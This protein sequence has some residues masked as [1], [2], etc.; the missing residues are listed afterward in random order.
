MELTKDRKVN[1]ISNENIGLTKYFYEVQSI[2]LSEI[3]KEINKNISIKQIL[4]EGEKLKKIMPKNL[5][6]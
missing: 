2:G 6:L 3:Y 1:D 5:T 4:E